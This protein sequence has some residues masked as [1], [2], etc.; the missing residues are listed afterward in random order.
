MPH[1]LLY[2]LE[3]SIATMLGSKKKGFVKRKRKSKEPHKAR[4]GGCGRLMGEWCK[5]TPRV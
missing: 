3:L 1:W 4:E 2:P 5:G